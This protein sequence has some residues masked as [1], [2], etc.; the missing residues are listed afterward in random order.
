MVKRVQRFPPPPVTLV[1]SCIPTPTPTPCPRSF[2]IVPSSPLA[3]SPGRAWSSKN[4]IPPPTPDPASQQEPAGKLPGGLP[5][6]TEK[7]CHKGVLGSSWGAGRETKIYINKNGDLL[8][9][10]W[11]TFK[12]IIILQ[13]DPFHCGNSNFVQAM[14]RERAKLAAL[15]PFHSPAHVCQSY[16][17]SQMNKRNKMNA[18]PLD[19][20]CFVFYRNDVLLNVTNGL[21]WK[22]PQSVS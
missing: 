13:S 20:F 19:R 4:R 17:Y 16:T 14:P 2:S 15:T 1:C 6:T 11:G 10:S 8:K 3:K 5:R 7:L 12:I 9:S 21:M 18:L 22:G